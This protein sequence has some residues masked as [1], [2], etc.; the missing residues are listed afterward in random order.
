MRS[1]EIYPNDGAGIQPLTVFFVA[2]P[3]GVGDLHGKAYESTGPLLVN[4]DE[5]LALG[6]RR[7]HHYDR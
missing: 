4:E 7:R 1:V 5:A 2:L 3:S 6:D